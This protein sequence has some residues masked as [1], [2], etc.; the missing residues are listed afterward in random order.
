MGGRGEL[1]SQPDW[2]PAQCLQRSCIPR[3]PVPPRPAPP[4]PVFTEAPRLLRA[5][6]PPRRFLPARRARDAR[7]RVSAGRAPLRSSRRQHAAPGPGAR[8]SNFAAL[9]LRLPLLAR[10][11]RRP[12][13]RPASRVP[14]PGVLRPAPLSSLTPLPPPPP[15]PSTSFPFL[16]TEN[17]EQPQ[18][19][20]LCLALT[21]SI[22]HFFPGNLLWSLLRPPLSRFQPLRH[23][24]PFLSPSLKYFRIL[25]SSQPHSPPPPVSS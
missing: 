11:R 14:R 19:A 7:F 12:G 5:R 2:R 1:P 10:L 17:L 8:P 23:P 13:R 24:F 18:P 4:S 9:A 25:P 16:P 15:R 21:I 6:P 3:Q 20:A 22:C